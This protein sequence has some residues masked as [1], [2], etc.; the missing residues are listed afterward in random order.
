M[1]NEPVFLKP[2]PDSQQQSKTVNA[3]VSSLPVQKN[4]SVQ[5]IIKIG[6]QRHKKLFVVIFI[7]LTCVLFINLSPSGNIAKDQ[8]H[9]MDQYVHEQNLIQFS[10]NG[11]SGTGIDNTTPWYDIYYKTKNTPDSLKTSF[12]TLL[13]TNDYTI[14]DIYFNPEPCFDSLGYFEYGDNG[15]TPG[16]GYSNNGGKP[17]WVIIAST[18][19]NRVYAEITNI[20]YSDSTG[21]TNRYKNLIGQR[22]VPAGFN[23]LH[24][25][26]STGKK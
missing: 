23:V 6:L 7:I 16:V 20:S 17:Y 25:S 1:D 21:T 3:S 24:V 15:C 18:S 19:A 22:A 9:F 11:D 5:Q 14:Q 26:L 4:S 2:T 8:Y 13:K 10:T 12:E